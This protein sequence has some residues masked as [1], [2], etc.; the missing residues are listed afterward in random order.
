M[1]DLARD[2]TGAR[3]PAERLPEAEAPCLAR[4][5]RPQVVERVS[6]LPPF[7]RFLEENRTTVFRYLTAAVGPIDADDVFQET[8]LAALRAYPRCNEAARLDRWILRI[9]S[10]KAIDHHRGAGRRPIPVAAP[11][12]RPTEVDPAGLFRGGG[13]CK[14]LPGIAQTEATRAQGASHMDERLRISTQEAERRSRQAAE[15]FRA[16]APD[17]GLVDVAVGTMGSPVGELLVA[18]TPRGLAAIAFEGDD[19]DRV[20]DRL[21]RGLSP[22]VLMAA[23]AT[24]DV[25]RELDEYFRGARRRFDLRLDRRLMSPFAKDVLGA[26]A[27]VPFGRL[28]TYGEIAGRIGRPKAARAVGAALGA[29]PIPIVVPC[30]RVIGAGGNLTGYGGGLPRKEL[31]LRLEGSLPAA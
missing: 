9:A 28:A 19:R 5:A 11:P 24:D 26:T 22:R 18:V 30:H 8:F 7:E 6:R 15:R 20:L 29:N 21:A 16:A 17:T 14:R 31:L 1:E 25:R 12:E 10:R 2:R 23:R 27:R 3:V 4:S 13:S